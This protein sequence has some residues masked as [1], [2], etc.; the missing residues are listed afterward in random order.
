MEDISRSP[1]G[2]AF[3]G[4]VRMRWLKVMYLANLIIA[5]PLGLA[6]LVAP[7]LMR[8]IMGVPPGDP[9]HF[10]LAAGAVQCAFGMAGAVGLWSPLKFSPVLLLQALYKSLFLGGVVLPLMGRGQLP[11]FAMPVSLLFVLFI[12]ED[13]IAVPFSY[14]FPPS[15]G[16]Q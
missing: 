8:G 1:T 11:D 12:I 7:E 6:V 5:F 3:S 9:I 2:E 15:D 14:L 13:L 10:S 16:A 4:P